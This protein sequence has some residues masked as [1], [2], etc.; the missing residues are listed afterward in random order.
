MLDQ[1]AMTRVI[2]FL[3]DALFESR[4]NRIIYGT[5]CYLHAMG[6]PVDVVSVAR[7]LRDNGMLSAVGGTRYLAQLTDSAPSPLQTEAAALWLVR[8][9]E[10]AKTGG[11]P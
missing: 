3:S 9:A 8:L 5:A 2:E 11:T 6:E 1:G 7:Q 10:L 4:A